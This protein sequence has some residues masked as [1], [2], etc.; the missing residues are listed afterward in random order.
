MDN[1]ETWGPI[2]VIWDDGSNTC[3]NP[4]PV[5]DRDTNTILLL[6]THNPCGDHKSEI[7]TCTSVGTRTVWVT[8]LH[9]AGDHPEKAAWS[10]PADITDRV[11]SPNWTWYATGPASVSSSGAA[12][13]SYPAVIPRRKRTFPWRT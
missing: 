9:L 6:M 4:C 5:Y 10:K 12:A 3:G 1:G 8:R 2:E 11:K 13:L 7:I